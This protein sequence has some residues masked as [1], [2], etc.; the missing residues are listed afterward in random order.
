MQFECVGIPPD[1]MS[2]PG[3][4]VMIRVRSHFKDLMVAGRAHREGQGTQQA[5]RGGEGYLIYIAGEINAS[6][7]RQFAAGRP[8]YLAP[9]AIR[10]L[11]PG[12][13][14][15]RASRVKHYICSLC[16]V[17]HLVG[18]GGSNLSSAQATDGYRSIRR[19]ISSRGSERLQLDLWTAFALLGRRVQQNE[20]FEK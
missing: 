14:D 3:V 17:C 7:S 5:A 15:T 20:R 11:S 4:S 18:R 8:P 12:H 2:G 6:P 10:A 13:L 1:P 19:A 9:A 16:P